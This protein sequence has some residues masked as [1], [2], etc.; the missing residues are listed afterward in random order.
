M[1]RERILDLG[2]AWNPLPDGCDDPRP[3]AWVR[4][5]LR[6]ELASG[7]WESDPRLATWLIVSISESN[8]P[9][10]I[11]LLRQIAGMD[12]LRDE[13]RAE[14]ARGLVR[15]RAPDV[16][17]GHPLWWEA[18][19]AVF[20]ELLADDALSDD[21]GQPVDVGGSTG[22]WVRALIQGRGDGFLARA[23]PILARNPTLAAADILI[24]QA[25]YHARVH[26]GPGSRA[27]HKLVFDLDPEDESLPDRLRGA[28]RSA[29]ILLG[30]D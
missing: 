21:G 28:V 29:R 6:E 14:A 23:A 2:R 26:D 5:R 4:D 10:D 15:R 9:E 24:E 8:H 30:S 16:E 18:N 13:L 27:F 25:A 19:E 20:L 12:G 1:T 22:T 17:S 11:V 7:A 3:N